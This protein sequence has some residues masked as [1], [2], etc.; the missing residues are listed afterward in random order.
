MAVAAT[1]TLSLVAASA[2]GIALAPM[3]SASAAAVTLSSTSGP[4]GGLNALTATT[5]SNTFLAGLNAEFQYKATTTSACSPFYSTP[6]TVAVGAGIV[7]VATPKILSAKKLAFTVP[8]TVTLVPVASSTAVNWLLCVYPG[9]NTTTSAVTAAATYTVAAAPTIALTSATIPGI[10]PSSGPALGGGS[11]TITGTGFTG[12]TTAS[13]TTAKIGSVSLTGVNWIN[14]TTLTATVPPQAAAAG[15]SVS[16]T[17]TGGTATLA[18]AYTYS[19]GIIVSP[20]TTTS[21]VATDVDIQGVGFSSLSLIHTTGSTIDDATS[22]VYITDGAYDPT[23]VTKADSEV[24]E[25]TNVLVISD[26]ELICTVNPAIPDGAGATMTALTNGTFTLQTVS[27]GT[28]GTHA[29]GTA[30]YAASI[31]SS[32]STFTVAPF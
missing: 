10:V 20:N 4:S 8:S 30:G 15:L 2:A 12:T 32:G 16:V 23:G 18:A 24:G 3:A 27:D 5:A 21:T 25:C 11:V 22:H 19:N 14:A 26:N 28:P 13:T 17:N 29:V 31:L 1:A 9:T 7:A 6:T